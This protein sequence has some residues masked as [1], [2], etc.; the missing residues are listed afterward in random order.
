MSGDQNAHSISFHFIS[1]HL[2]SL[3]STHAIMSLQTN[4]PF[5]AEI[6]GK[7]ALL[8]SQGLSLEDQ[9]IITNGR[10]SFIWGQ[11]RE[12]LNTT[13]TDWRHSRARRAYLKIQ[14]F[15]NH[16]FLVAVLVFTPTRCSQKSFDEV[17]NHLIR[18]DINSC[19]FDLDPITKTFFESTAAEQ[20]LAGDK[21]YLDFM[22]S[23][24]PQKDLRGK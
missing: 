2:I 11:P 15:S 17:V 23:L 16:L 7:I 10:L 19:V 24:F 9:K 4:H 8:K 18:L 6:F 22:K 20:G 21:R 3:Y 13:T 12:E 5:S 1:C 14:E